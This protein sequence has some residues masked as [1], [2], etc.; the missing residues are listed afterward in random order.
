MKGWNFDWKRYRATWSGGGF[1]PNKMEGSRGFCGWQS[2]RFTIFN[3]NFV[4]S[5]NWALVLCIGIV[6]EKSLGVNQFIHKIRWPG[7]TILWIISW[8]DHQNESCPREHSN[9]WNRAE[10][11]SRNSTRRETFAI[12]RPLTSLYDLEHWGVWR[13]PPSTRTYAEMRCPI[14]TLPNVTLRLNLVN[15]VPSYLP[16]VGSV[17]LA[18]K[19]M[20]SHD[21]LKIVG[22]IVSVAF[23]IF[24]NLQD[25]LE[26]TFPH[27]KLKKKDH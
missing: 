22:C 5:R 10:R 17:L 15:M 13:E 4:R 23:E 6:R 19:S 14:G 27:A 12:P 7:C 26:L 3:I 9:S 16:W 18:E 11:G 1:L 25:P 24:M 20:P 8:F 2:S 21:S